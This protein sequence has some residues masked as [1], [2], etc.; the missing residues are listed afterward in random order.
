VF[1]KPK[2][3][4]RAHRADHRRLRRGLRHR[5]RARSRASHWRNLQAPARGRHR[6]AR[7]ST[8]PVAVV[9]PAL[10]NAFFSATGNHVRSLPLKGHYLRK[11]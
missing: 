7:G 9:A 2:G 10:C 8:N 5:R 6:L 3:A 11:P 4:R 1:V